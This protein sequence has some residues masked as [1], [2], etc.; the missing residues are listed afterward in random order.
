MKRAL[1]Y[2]ECAGRAGIVRRTLERAIAEGY[3]PPVIEIS[4]RRRGVLEDDFEAWLESRRRPT[5]TP[6]K[7]RRQTRPRTREA[8]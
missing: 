7:Q 2:D 8:V 3:G 1:S 4:A 5:P 6:T